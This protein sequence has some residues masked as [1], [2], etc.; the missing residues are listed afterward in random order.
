MSYAH[1]PLI[2]CVAYA[3]SA[4]P[5]NRLYPVVSPVAYEHYA[6]QLLLNAVLFDAQG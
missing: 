2:P 5:A 4:H 3:Q 6:L 1:L